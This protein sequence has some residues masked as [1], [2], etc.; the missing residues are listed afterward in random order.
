MRLVRRLLIVDRLRFVFRRGLVSLG[1]RLAGA[2]AVT[3]KVFAVEGIFTVVD[4][5]VDF[6]FGNVWQRRF[7]A[8]LLGSAAPSIVGIT[9][10]LC[11]GGD[12]VANHFL[13]TQLCN[14]RRCDHFGD[15]FEFPVLQVFVDHKSHKGMAVHDK[16][17]LGGSV[18]KVCF[19]FAGQSGV[20]TEH[21]LVIALVDKHGVKRGRKLLASADHDAALHLLFGFFEDLDGGYRGVRHY[22]CCAFER[23]FHLALE[24]RED[25][26]GSLFRRARAPFFAN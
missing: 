4:R 10:G 3:F 5:A 16:P 7:A 14:D 21:A 19:G 17:F 13:L 20:I 18:F 6:F 12:A 26:H 9:L 22:A 8:R 2:L 15:Y 23:I 25:T 24:L 11:G 1:Q